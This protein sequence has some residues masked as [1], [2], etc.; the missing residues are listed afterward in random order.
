MQTFMPILSNMRMT[1][2]NCTL[3][4]W[5]T[6][7]K[8]IQ[9]HKL[10]AFTKTNCSLQSPC[11]CTWQ[12]Q[13]AYYC[14]DTYDKTKL[15]TAIMIHMTKTN[16]SLQSYAYDKNKLHF[17]IIWYTWQNQFAHCKNDAY[18]KTKLLAAIM[19]PMTIA[20]C[21]LQSWCIWKNQIAHCNHDAYVKSKLLTPIMMLMTKP[22]YSL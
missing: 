13:N 1:K 8:Q 11:V 17:A 14:H 15:S 18:D 16:C 20:N 10:Y 3:Q 9:Y 19:M 6:H 2:T 4:K 22:N 7:Q 21:S 12:N 5:Y